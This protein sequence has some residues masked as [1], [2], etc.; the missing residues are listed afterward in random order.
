M[1]KNTYGKSG[2]GARVTTSK[3]NYRVTKAKNELTL[4]CD[5]CCERMS[6]ECSKPLRLSWS[7]IV[8]I[9]YA[10]ESGM[11]ELCWDKDNLELLCEKHHLEIE[12]LTAEERLEYY[13]SRK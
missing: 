1:S 8:S 3:I 6:P 13:N 4:D 2:G 9:K 5:N 10:K 7:H 11:A 12:A